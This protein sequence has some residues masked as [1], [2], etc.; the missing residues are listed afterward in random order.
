ML[1]LLIGKDWIKNRDKLL[2]M[3]ADDIR[4]DKGGRI[5]MVPELISH[6][7]ERRLCAI[8][9]DSLSRYAEV[10]SFTRL[11]RVVA[12]SVGHAAPECLDNGGRIVAMASAVQQLHS[13]LKAY[14]SV[15]TKPEF[16]TGLID[17]VDEFK[18]CCI[19][20]RDL[21]EA[22]K[23]SA[24][25]FAQKLEEL[26]LI[27]ECY[28]GICR[29]GK[30]DPR[31]QMTWLLEELESSSFAKEH[32]FY[33]DGFP[34]FTRQH[35]NIVNYLVRESEHVTISLNCDAIDSSLLAFE[36]AGQT[37]A[38]IYREAR[39]AGV[40]IEVINVAGSS[41]DLAAV[42]D[43][44]FQ[45]GID[46][47][48][49]S[50]VLCKSDSVYH[51]CL[52]AAERISDLV[53]NGA[54]YRDIGVVYTDPAS[55]Q[56]A[57][58]MVLNRYHIPIYL[59]G[60]EPILDKSVIAMVI[61]AMDTALDGFNTVDV[62]RYL[63]SVLSPVPLMMADRLENYATLWS[64]DGKAWT[65]DW[66]GHP[67]GLSDKWSDFDH[68]T[69]KE[70]NSARSLVIDPLVAL[71]DAF[72]NADNV[73]QQVSALYDFL[74]TIKLNERLDRLANRLDNNGDNR[75]AQILNQLWDILI[76]ALE[77]LH[78]VLGSTR[79]DIDAFTRLF[80]LLLS[81][82]DVGT[83]PP[84]L[85]AVYA[86][87]VS[88]MRCQQVQ[89]LLVLGAGEGNLPSYSGSTGVL[90]D[91]ERTA[92]RQMGVPLTGGAIEGLQAEFAEIYGVFAGAQKTISV[93][94]SGIQPSFVY[95]RLLNYCDNEL[96]LDSNMETACA[97]AVE[98]GAFLVRNDDLESARSLGV[99]YTFCDIKNAIEHTQGKLSA[100]GV[101]GLYGEK[102][103]LSA[104]QIDK[105]AD[106]RYHYFLRYG[107]R[108]NELKPAMV[109]P[110]EFGTYVHAVL[111]NTAREICN[112][113][114]FRN[115]T[116]AETLAVAQRFSKQYAA[117]HFSQL[118]EV[119]S[120]YLFGRNVRELELIVRELWSELHT[121]SF[122]PVGFEVSFGEDMQLPPVEI[123]GS[124]L[125]AQLRGF[126]DRVDRWSEGEKDY[127]R[128]VDYKTGR[129][130]FDYCDVLNGLGLQMLIYMFAL[131]DGGFFDRSSIPAGVQ[132]FPA[133]VPLVSADGRLSDED[134]EAL[135]SKSWKRKGLL[136][137]D[138][139]VLAA[140]E[141]PEIP[142]RMPYKTRK[143]G[144][145]DGDLADHKQFALLKRYIFDML[146]KMVDTIASGD[147]DPNPYTRGSSHNAC[148]FCPYGTVCHK[149]CVSGRRNYRA[150]S[151]KE[152][153]ENITKEVR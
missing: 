84:V 53:R 148:A 8:A 145:L 132:Y 2:Q 143:D 62:L 42:C 19:T 120:N 107:L 37:A 98:A 89:H 49:D 123:A 56:N 118:S 90:S 105:F 109:D 110:A 41:S 101:S 60:T 23:Q 44:L 126:V 6:D 15:E 31:D 104:S 68:G 103:K 39:K 100:D 81:Q 63:K 113:G 66:T 22:S 152:F 80:K 127:F 43:K 48:V 3:I 33:I 76:G 4:N 34:D 7:T 87:T 61:A 47:S 58:G 141:S 52:G 114:G 32:V 17:T 26:S 138:G 88:T 5:L 85:D 99:E 57:L 9:G 29:Q 150:I 92:L 74:V 36:K 64:V 111:E 55:Y 135:R 131:E 25:S 12:D 18:R 16:L 67:N 14:A 115:Y 20:P 137:C 91:Q 86:G 146:R 65:K 130:D 128:V 45:G 73:S 10:L 112:N 147:V 83:I 116:E 75:G 144:T 153:W 122:A 136:L 40:E 151:A 94:Y 21:S 134:A 46:R 121:I 69:L 102:L 129:K 1:T 82:Y 70:L 139:D 24:G 59:T 124:E 106:C 96:T 35:M 27:L 119:R 93:S 140:M 28:D 79:W 108:V 11:A 125:K 54:R 78:D 51:E 97:D 50:L 95:R 72:R 13:K 77:Q 38:E 142:N 133:R 71:R 149:S 30:V 117:E